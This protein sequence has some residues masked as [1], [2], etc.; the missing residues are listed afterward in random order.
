M[1]STW[2]LLLHW[3]MGS[4]S[5]SGLSPRPWMKMIVALCSA[6]G[7]ITSGLGRT[8]MEISF[9]MI[10]FETCNL[11]IRVDVKSVRSACCCCALL[12]QHQYCTI[13][14]ETRDWR[15]SISARL[16]PSLIYIASFNAN[17]RQLYV[18]VSESLVA[19]Q[20]PIKACRVTPLKLDALA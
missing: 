11:T 6:K 1:L 8:E 16:T 5:V 20:P 7:S 17:W 4:C 2:P 18:D 13:K 9:S 10:L 15:E 12:L 3:L 19:W 14:T